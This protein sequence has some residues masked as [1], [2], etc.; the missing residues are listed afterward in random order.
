MLAFLD[1][2]PTEFLLIAVLFL[3]LFGADRV[4][5]LARQLGRATAQFRSAASGLQQQLDRERGEAFVPGDAVPPEQ[6]AQLL[7]QEGELAR[8]QRA[9]SELGVDIRGKGPD[10]LREAIAARLR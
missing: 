8:L 2:G 7:A 9:A 10:E 1:V 4:P 5:D 6:K 3:L